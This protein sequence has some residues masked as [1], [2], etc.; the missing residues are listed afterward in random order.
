MCAPVIQSVVDLVTGGGD[1]GGGGSPAAAAPAAPAA[2]AVDPAEEA[3]KR[4]E[5]KAAAERAAEAER[6]RIAAEQKAARISQGRTSI[7]DAFA[8]FDTSFYNN[9]S[10]SY[11]DYATNNLNQQY[12]GQLGSLIS[13][14]A[15]TGGLNSAARTRGVEA[16]RSQYDDAMSKL[17]TK[18]DEVISSLRS[19]VDSAKTGLYSQNDADPGVDSI[20]S[21]AKAKATELQTNKNFS[22]LATLMI[23]PT[24]FATGRG[25]VVGSSMGGS[26]NPALFSQIRQSRGGGY[27]VA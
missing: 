21:T 11:N 13:S 19:G 17:P 1:S 24:Q 27:T 22:P 5:E 25:S 9:V 18:A 16:L 26:S 14:L 6:Q 15:R 3:R 8:P 4:E 2:P 10:Q 12:Q 7:D 20:A 23:D